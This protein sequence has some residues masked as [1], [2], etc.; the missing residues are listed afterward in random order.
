MRKLDFIFALVLLFIFAV[1]SLIVT[2]FGAGIYEDTISNSSVNSTARTSLSYVSE[3]IHAGDLRGSVRIGKFDDCDSIIIA[4]EISGEEYL[5]YIYAYD[6]QLK[7]LF[8]KGDLN[9]SKTDNTFTADNGTK[10]IDI[11]N[12][13]IKQ[14]SN[15]LFRFTCTDADGT[16]ASALVSIRTA[17]QSA[18]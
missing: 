15:K 16:A 11:K 7:E 5:T 13:E 3:K 6:G 18:E 12:F 9:S 10:I 1:S 17:E 4:S 8:V 14:E 2:L